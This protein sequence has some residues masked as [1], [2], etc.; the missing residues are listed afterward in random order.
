MHKWITFLMTALVGST[1]SYANAS[2]GQLNFEAGYRHD[3][4]SWSNHFPSSDPVVSTKT[5]FDDIDIFQIGLQGRTNVGCNFYLRGSA[6][7]GWVLDGNF[8]R[9]ASLY[10]NSGS[11]N[12][13]RS[14][15]HKSLIDDRYVFGVAAA[16]GYPFYFCDCT[17]ALAPVLGYAFDQQTLRVQN[18]DFDCGYN[19]SSYGTCLDHHECC[20]H[21]FSNRWYGPFVGV[22]FIYR[23]YCQCWDLY[24]ELEYHWG[25]F[26][27]KRS[28]RDDFTI[29]DCNQ[30]RRSNDARG[31]VFA[32]G[33][34]YDLGNCWTA[35]FSV[36]FQDW[37][38]HRRHHDD[39]GHDSS[40]DSSG[41][42][43]HAKHNHKWRSYAIN[44]TIGHEY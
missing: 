29:G 15:C 39:Y 13:G 25:Q 37:K 16:I 28:V 38:G 4:I 41:I 2:L 44:L 22:D 7:W 1:L 14:D 26:K 17:M 20:N 23:P 18:K 43:G 3:D 9:G 12:F 27:G 30:N 5:K 11:R 42:S 24:A 34:D 36:K 33:A 21:T 35:G 19:N 40:Y 32:A 31:W 8:E 10:E 6:Y